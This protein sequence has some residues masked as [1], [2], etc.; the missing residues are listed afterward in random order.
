VAVTP[1]SHDDGD[2]GQM[3]RYLMSAVMSLRCVFL[4]AF[5]KLGECDCERLIEKVLW[6]S[7]YH[8]LRAVC[9]GFYLAERLSQMP[10]AIGED[11][12]VLPGGS[13]LL[14][15]ETGSEPVKLSHDML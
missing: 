1:D 2:R 12:N 11:E 8:D 5:C 4:G 13:T 15:Q 3:T 9:S 6:T 7:Q 10:M 14:P